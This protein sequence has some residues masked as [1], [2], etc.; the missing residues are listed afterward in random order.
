MDKTLANSLSLIP[1]RTRGSRSIKAARTGRPALI[2]RLGS[3]GLREPIVDTNPTE[4]KTYPE[5]LQFCQMADILNLF[6]SI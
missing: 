4:S 5:F 2:H 6:Y 3:T 1:E